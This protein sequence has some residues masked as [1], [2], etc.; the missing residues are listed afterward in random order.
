MAIAQMNW[1]RMLYP[2]DDP[3]MQEFADHLDE[4]YNIAEQAPGFIWRIDGTQLT[5]EMSELGDDGKT[6]TTVSVWES[7]SDLHHYTYQG[8]HG[9]YLDRAQEWFEVVEGPQLVMW[10][11][12]KDVKPSFKDA[13][14]RMDYLKEHGDSDYAYGW[15]K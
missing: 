4:V 7:I 3:R 9:M 11:V 1:G 15:P 5:K 6:S 10:N 12:E 14:K 13:Q 2:L 8:Q